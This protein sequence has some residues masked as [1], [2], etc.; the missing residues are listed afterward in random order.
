[1]G[2][3]DPRLQGLVHKLMP[4]DV[5]VAEHGEHLET[6]LGSCVSIIVTD[7]RRTIAAMC[8]MVHTGE[9]ADHH[10][11]ATAWGEAALQAMADGL[12]QRGIT[13]GLCE[14]FL[15]GGGNMFPTLDIPLTVG[16]DNA[17]WAIE[18]MDRLRIRVVQAD[19]GGQVYRKVQW[20]VGP[21]APTV[22]CVAI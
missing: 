9:A 18:A 6:L 2:H 21:H 5:V 1:M 20:T 22:Q 3:P 19:L 15:F 7:P 4:G 16:E 17:H 13:L 12:R 14:A 10:E 8:H 11:P